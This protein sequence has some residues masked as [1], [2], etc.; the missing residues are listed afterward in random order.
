MRVLHICICGPFTDGL[1]Y[2]ENELIEQHVV[3]GHAVTVIAATET[4][5]PDKA[6]T[7]TNPG[8]SQLRCGATL[9]RV[10][11]LKMIPRWLASKI[12]AHNGLVDHLEAVKPDRILFHGLTAWDLLTVAKYVQRTHGAKLFADCHEDFNNSAK[13]WAS[14]ELLHRLFYRPLF[15]HSL[16]QIEAVLCVTVESMNFAIDFYGS[17]RAKTRLFPLGCAIDRPELAANRRLAFRARHGL[18]DA[19]IVVVQTGK[20]DHTKQLVSALRA[21]SS[22]SSPDIKFVIAGRMTDD[23]EAECL[24]LIHGD[25]RITNL[26]WQSTDELRTVL[27]GADCFLQ[28]FGQTV[29]TQMAMGYGCV[30]LGQD[31]PSHRWLVGD[32]GR[33]FRDPSELNAV[34]QWIVDNKGKLPRLKNATSQFA[35]ANLDYTQLARQIVS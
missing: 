16:G 26:G 22:V 11:Y 7:H 13:T 21:F 15:R 24:P 29:T 34:F 2:Q 9:I 30:I 28:P 19:D 31:L 5:G 33:L 17:P 35:G 25:R 20:L 27:A 3:A 12:R 8:V 14:R 10:P 18:V 23:V 4:Y 1:A 32:N 6:V